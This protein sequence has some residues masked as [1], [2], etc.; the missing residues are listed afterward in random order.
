MFQVSPALEFYRP[1]EVNASPVSVARD[2]RIPPLQDCGLTRKVRC[3]NTDVLMEAKSDVSGRVG[4][5]SRILWILAS[6]G[7]RLLRPL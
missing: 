5:R 4:M 2:D 6:S 7:G 3:R 1:A